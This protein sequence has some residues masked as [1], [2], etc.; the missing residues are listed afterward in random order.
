M[1]AKPMSARVGEMNNGKVIVSGFDKSLTLEDFM[2]QTEISRDEILDIRWL[3][4]GSIGVHFKEV[5]RAHAFAKQ[6]NRRP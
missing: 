1:F 6:I 4:E 5:T 2:N 3:Q